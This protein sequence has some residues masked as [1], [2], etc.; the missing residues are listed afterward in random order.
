MTRRDACR[1]AITAGVLATTP[2]GRAAVAREERPDD[3]G[4]ITREQEPRNLESPFSAL[5]GP[6]TPVGR[7]YV[8]DHFPIPKIDAKAW[9]LKVEGAVERPLTIGYDD[10]RAMT[11]RTI[12]AVLECAGNG[13]VFLAPR[14]RGAQ[15]GMGAVGNAE[16]VGVPLSAILERAGVKSGA[17]EVVLEGADSGEIR[18]EPK[19]PGKIPFARSVPIEKARG[20][21][22]LAYRMNGQEL[23]LTHGFPVRAL[24][25]GWY[26]MAAV[27]WLS[28]VVVADRP[29]V[30]YF[31][32]LDYATWERRDGLA[33]LV[34]IGEIQVKSQIARPSAYEVIKAGAD[35]RVFGA[36]WT[37]ESDVAKVEVSTDGGSSWSEASLIGSPVRHS[38][39]L[40]DYTWKAPS[41]G[42]YKLMARATDARGRTQPATRDVD[43]APHMISHVLPVEVEA[44]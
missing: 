31:Q 40:W 18:D 35:Y 36:A 14:E 22:L 34:P 41:A 10:L 17:V 26:G 39:R 38:W 13:R 33:S 32:T 23:T 1:K 3:P 27:K 16:W 44:R 8:R 4:L 21:V 11:A 30:G 12:A 9:S 15:W 43:S 7:F 28:R 25:P 29:F 24:V 2:I 19:S 37:G 20:D 6:I 5:D 42:P